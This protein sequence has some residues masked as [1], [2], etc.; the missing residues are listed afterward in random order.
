M[1]FSTDKIEAMIYNIRNLKVMLDSDLAK[2]YGVETKAL[3]RQVRRNLTRFPSDFLIEPTLDELEDLRRQFGTAN[4]ATNWNNK[5]RTLPMLFSEN[6]VAMLSTVL[7][8]EQ[9]IQINIA[10]MRTFTKLRSF[11]SMENSLEKRVSELERN[12]NQI[13]KVVF[14]RLDDVDHKLQIYTEAVTPRLP[15]NRKKIGL[16]PCKKD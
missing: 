1:S 9:A 7:K 6:G 8:S 10:I 12:T 4:P 14:E 15:N 3:N 16:K 2:L 5:R 11:L 13:F